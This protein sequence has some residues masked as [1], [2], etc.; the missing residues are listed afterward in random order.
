MSGCI[1]NHPGQL[2]CTYDL[3]ILKDTIFYHLTVYLKRFVLKKTTMIR[4]PVVFLAT[5]LFAL[6]V[7]GQ[8]PE[9]PHLVKVTVDPETGYDII[10][11][12]HSPSNWIDYYE[13]AEVVRPNISEPPAYHKIGTADTAA[14]SFVNTN[15]ASGTHSVGYTVWAVDQIASTLTNKSLYD[16]PDSTIYTSAVFDSCQSTITL[17]WTDYNSW[18]GSI[19]KYTVYQRLGSGLYMALDTLPEGS[20][21]YVISGVNENSV[22][23]LF[24]EATAF[25]DNT[26]MQSTSNRV[27]LY[28]AMSVIPDTVNADFATLGDGNTIDLAFSID[29][30]SQLQH[31]KLLRSNSANGAGDTIATFE[32]ADKN[33][34]YNDNIAFTSGIYYYRLLAFNNCGK[35]VKTSN[36]ACNVLLNESH[37]NLLVSLKWNEYYDWN[38]GVSHYEITRETGPQGTSSETFNAGNNIAFTDDLSSGINYTDPQST[39]VCYH[40]TAYESALQG[41]TQHTSRSN[42]VCVNLEPEIRIPNAF[43][44]NSHDG[45]NDRFGPIFS[46]MPEKYN[47]IIYNRAGLKIWEGAE[48]WDGMV[49]GKPV[50]E[51]VYMYHLKI[52]NYENNTRVYAG[53]V[54]VVYR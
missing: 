21:S 5:V 33:V 52:F 25:H 6:M 38:R 48:A 35:E 9:R 19:L 37:D 1:K 42:T 41:D 40:V 12:E 7:R 36:P 54:T 27:D 15:T 39:R 23:Q 45:I 26:L 16:D 18:R 34:H 49:N 50:P 22:Y 8:Q 20:N 47:L 24:I 44:P 29:P 14:V 43:I 17:A 11:W 3:L 31:Y 30:N 4:I 53:Q 32:T 10:Y 13:I 2:G 46:F 51:E 28:T